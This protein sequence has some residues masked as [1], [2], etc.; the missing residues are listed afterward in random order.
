M[1]LIL[2][3]NCCVCILCNNITTTTLVLRNSCPLLKSDKT[4]RR[5][6]R[7]NEPMAKQS[8]HTHGQSR[9]SCTELNTLTLAS[10]PP[11]GFH[12]TSST[13]APKHT[14]QRGS[15]NRHKSRNGACICATNPLGHRRARCF[16]PFKCFDSSSCYSVVWCLPS[17]C[18]VQPCQFVLFSKKSTAT[19]ASCT[20]DTRARDQDCVVLAG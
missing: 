11:P 19:S 15:N 5:F 3:S 4:I 13:P 20:F 10:T 17:F 9:Y 2:A 7:T 12:N 8:K 16:S 6:I 1:W 14:W 18:C